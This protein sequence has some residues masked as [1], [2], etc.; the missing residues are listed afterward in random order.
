MSSPPTRLFRPRTIPVR[1]RVHDRW[2]RRWRDPPVGG[3]STSTLGLNQPRTVALAVILQ[4]I[5][6]VLVVPARCSQGSD[7]SKGGQLVYENYDAPFAVAQQ[8]LNH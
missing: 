2:R 7:V 3:A 6:K 4:V 1:R 5:P 8:V